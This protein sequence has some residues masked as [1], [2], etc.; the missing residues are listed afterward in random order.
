MTVSILTLCPPAET[1]IPRATVETSQEKTTA[2]AADAEARQL[3]VAIARGDNAAFEQLYE[4][5]HRRLMRLALMLGRGDETLAHEAVQGTFIVA[6]KRLRRVEGEE[7]LWNWLA[8]VA[9]QQIARAMRQRN[10]DGALVSADDMPE[11]AAAAE[12]DGRF[13]EILDAALDCLDREER[14]IIEQFYFERLS[15][16]EMAE[17]LNITAKA[18]SSRLERA[19]A[20]LRSLIAKELSYET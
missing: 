5:Y 13:E 6:A 18:V 1:L 11:R 10:R 19:R 17:H 15:H 2:S 20:R 3:V 16:K 14:E 9:R 8:Q 12:S 4:G 7:H